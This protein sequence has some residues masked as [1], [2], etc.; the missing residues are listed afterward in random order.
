MIFLPAPVIGWLMQKSMRVYHHIYT[1]I[2]QPWI[3]IITY[4]AIPLNPTKQLIPM[5]YCGN[6]FHMLIMCSVKKS[7]KCFADRYCT[8]ERLYL[9]NA[10][11]ELR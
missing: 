3:P 7:A 10:H 6:E 1:K 9:R 2:S 4:N 11:S 5:I 8:M